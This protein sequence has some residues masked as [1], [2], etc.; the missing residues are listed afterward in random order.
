MGKEQEAMNDLED[1]YKIHDTHIMSLK[2]GRLWD[3][4]RRDPRLQK[5]LGE[6]NYPR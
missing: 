3:P 2:I 5:Q 6:M 1:C 4:M